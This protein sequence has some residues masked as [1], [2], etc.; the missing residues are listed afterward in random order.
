MDVLGKQ[1]GAI[2]HAVDDHEIAKHTINQLINS[3]SS[4][5]VDKETFSLNTSEVNIYVTLAK[6]YFCPCHHQI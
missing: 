5:T 4:L 2:K 1:N 3:L 6:V